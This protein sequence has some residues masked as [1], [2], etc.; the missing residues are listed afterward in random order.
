MSSLRK[1][2]TWS[3]WVWVIF[4]LLWLVSEFSAYGALADILFYPFLIV[5]SFTIGLITAQRLVRNG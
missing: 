3:F 2:I 5:G 1:A 4:L